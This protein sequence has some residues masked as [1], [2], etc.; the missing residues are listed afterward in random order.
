[1]SEKNHRINLKIKGEDALSGPAR[2]ASGSIRRLKDDFEKVSQSLAGKAGRGLQEFQQSLLKISKINIRSDE[3]R[4]AQ[5]E[6]QK[7]MKAAREMLE[8]KK[9]D[10]KIEE[11][12][13]SL[14]DFKSKAA[15]EELYKL[16]NARV[17][18]AGKMD[19]VRSSALGS[20]D[21]IG[22]LGFDVSGLSRKG[23]SPADAARIQKAIHEHARFNQQALEAEEV[24]AKLAI[25]RY[26]GEVNAAKE[27]KKLKE[28]E[29]HN[30]R[31]IKQEKKETHQA[32]RDHRR[33]QRLKEIAFYEKMQA[34]SELGQMGGRVTGF[35]RNT[36]AQGMTVERALSRVNAKLILPEIDPTQNPR[37]FKEQSRR[38]REEAL[39]ISRET[40]IP[41]EQ[42]LLGYEE[43]AK[44]GFQMKDISRDSAGTLARTSLVGDLP[45][46]ELVKLTSGVIAGFKMPMKESMTPVANTLTT[47]AD[48]TQI[49]LNDL[50]YTFK[51]IA[52]YAQQAGVSFPQVSAYTAL[53]GKGGIKGEMAGTALVN[54]VQ[55]LASP[56]SK[57]KKALGGLEVET[58]DQTTGNFRDPTAIL[59]D[60]AVAMNKRNLGSAERL[61]VAEKIFGRHGGAGGLQLLSTVNEQIEVTIDNQK[62]LVNHFD[63]MVSEIDRAQKADMIAKKARVMTDDLQGSTDRLKAS[64][65]GFSTVIEGEMSDPL[66][67]LV[68]LLQKATERLSEFSAAN[69]GLAKAFGYGGAAV[70][71]GSGVLEGTANTVLTFAGLKALGAGKWLSG[72]RAL[73]P[74]GAGA[75]AAAAGAGALEVGAAAGVAGAAGAGAAGAGTAAAGTAAAATAGGGLLATIGLPLLALAGIGGLGYLGY[76][77]FSDDPEEEAADAEFIK[78]QVADI[79]KR[80]QGYQSGVFEEKK[81]AVINNTF[82]M[83]G[84]QE[85]DQKV[86]DEINKKI[87]DSLRNSGF[88]RE[89]TN[90]YD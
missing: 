82:N 62:K 77:L 36:L 65:Q 34:V 76:K 25:K 55:D 64:A 48:L 29:L 24:R 37:A 51:Y 90:L 73:I 86:I 22:K 88:E 63:Y 21:R 83:Y 38:I 67:E 4:R 79:D 26:D 18:L 87:N 52:P 35:M 75:G 20:V 3:L 53:L 12:I 68:D 39:A 8:L 42:I 32:E 31:R 27:L 66:R 14:S 59:R 71:A 46:G 9:Q 74:F 81:T 19:R 13:K 78:A 58:V 61:D 57:A 45:M 5:A 60:L 7:Y 50:L 54:L 44:S 72:L 17:E 11:H 69:P 49:D 15:K 84:V 47:I 89:K 28:E 1:M 43:M 33:D 23:F 56:T 70:S 85:T 80:F 40:G 16:R 41:A 2:E 30:E 6:M 10:R